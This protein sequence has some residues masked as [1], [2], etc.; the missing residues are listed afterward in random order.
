LESQEILLL[1]QGA[2]GTTGKPLKGTI[3]LIPDKPMNVRSITLLFYGKMKVS[4][5][6]GITL[7]NKR[8]N[9]IR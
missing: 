7:T 1:D 5:I 2:S 3:K 4:W 8:K 9:R 6:E